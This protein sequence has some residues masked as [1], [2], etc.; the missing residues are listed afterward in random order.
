[1]ENLKF[2]LGALYDPE[3]VTDQTLVRFLRARDFDIERSCA[4]LKAYLVRGRW[5][6]GCVVRVVS[7]SYIW[8][9]RSGETRRT[10][11]SSQSM[12]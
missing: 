3:V 4:M 8:G 1:M 10:R 9:R 11:T 12:R 7:S 5:G 6:M 2:E